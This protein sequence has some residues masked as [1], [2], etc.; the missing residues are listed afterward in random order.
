MGGGGGGGGWGGQYNIIQ[1]IKL[2]FHF[3]ST[4][5][6]LGVAALKRYLRK[7]KKESIN[8][9]INNGALYKTATGTP[10]LLNVNVVAIVDVVVVVA[11]SVV[12]TL[13]KC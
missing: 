11:N 12:I 2:F 9:S 13:F 10:R 6:R 5:Y 7:T 3:Q 1:L 8:W 4:S